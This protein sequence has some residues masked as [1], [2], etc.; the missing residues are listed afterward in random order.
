MLQQAL[1]LTIRICCF[2]HEYGQHMAKHIINFSI[3]RS[4]YLLSLLSVGYFLLVS[5]WLASTAENNNKH[6]ECG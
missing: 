4:K 1:M 3:P 2:Y 5:Y 6:H